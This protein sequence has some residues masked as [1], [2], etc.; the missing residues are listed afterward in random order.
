MRAGVLVQANQPLDGRSQRKQSSRTVPQQL[1]GQESTGVYYAQSEK[2]HSSSSGGREALPRRMDED[3]AY[4]IQCLHY[5]AVDPKKP[6]QEDVVAPTAIRRKGG[7]WVRKIQRPSGDKS[8]LYKL[9]RPFE[10]SVEVRDPTWTSFV[11]KE[12]SSIYSQPH[13][14]TS[15]YRSFLSCSDTTDKSLASIKCKAV[16]YVEKAYCP[17]HSNFKLC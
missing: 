8:R 9:R 17:L 15:D 6:S 4:P 2:H 12:Q 3:L 13:K 7:L 5:H 1:R 16:K 10:P 11:L 14:G